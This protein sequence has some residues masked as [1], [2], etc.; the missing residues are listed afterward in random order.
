MNKKQVF[1]I[2]LGDVLKEIDIEEER[3][4]GLGY[5]WGETTAKDLRLSVNDLIKDDS[6]MLNMSKTVNAIFSHKT[7]KM[8]SGANSSL[9]AVVRNLRKHRKE[10]SDS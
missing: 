5:R 1:L 2:A 8:P 3:S 6:Q 9:E 7:A 4:G 10:K